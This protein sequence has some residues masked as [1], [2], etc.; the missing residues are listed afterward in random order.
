M[1]DP[2]GILLMAGRVDPVLREATHAVEAELIELRAL[3][4]AIPGD[5]KL[6][7]VQWAVKIAAETINCRTTDEPAALTR[8]YDAWSSLSPSVRAALRNQPT[9]NKD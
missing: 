4:D 6:A 2:M 3:R 8:F 9:D 7:T 1:R 5:D